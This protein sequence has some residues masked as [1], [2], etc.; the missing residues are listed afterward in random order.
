MVSALS[1]QT[2]RLG[3]CGLLLIGRTGQAQQKRFPQGNMEEEMAEGTVKWFND[4]KG[5]GFIEQDNGPDVF[6][7]FSQIS[8]DGFKSLAEGDRVSFDVSQGQKGPQA[9]NVRKI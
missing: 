6:V 5:F 9:S 4:A 7:H 3:F 2:D 8:G 1:E